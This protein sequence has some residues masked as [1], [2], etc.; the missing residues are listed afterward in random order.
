M[1]PT[2]YRSGI[3]RESPRKVQRSHPGK[4]KAH[5]EPSHLPHSTDNTRYRQTS[6]DW[7]GQTKATCVHYCTK[8]IWTTSLYT[9]STLLTL[10]SLCKFHKI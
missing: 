9:A 10:L 2:K 1:V 8:K 7:P 6:R 3:A 4:R 5:A